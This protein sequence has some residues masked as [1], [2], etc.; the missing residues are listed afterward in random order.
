MKFLEPT[1]LILI[2]VIVLILFGPKR[3]PDLGKSFRKSMRAFKE[4]AQSET[5]SASSDDAEASDTNGTR[6][7]G[8]AGSAEKR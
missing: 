7:S 2:L 8:R 1:G 6:D 3:L 5:E 4:E